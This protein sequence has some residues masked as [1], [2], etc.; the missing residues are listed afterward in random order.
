ME[1]FPKPG[2]LNPAKGSCLISEP[3][4]PDPNFE[5]S[6][7]LLCENNEDGS[8][9]FVLN[10]PSILTLSEVLDEKPALD[11]PLYVGG[12]VQQDT[13]HFIHRRPD[14]IDEAVPLGNG[15]YWGGNFEQ[16]VN[17]LRSGIYLDEDFKFFIGYS[18]W[19]AGQLQKELEETSWIVSEK[20]DL[21]TIFVHGSEEIWGDILRK[22]G[23]EFK[24]FANYPLDPRLN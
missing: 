3:F 20:T 18:G 4:L 1:F 2:I 10:K 14:L 22:M 7:V 16:V 21:D 12:P 6:V 23:G 8:F 13:L 15:V 24:M 9:G 5:R 11:I 19:T 17:L